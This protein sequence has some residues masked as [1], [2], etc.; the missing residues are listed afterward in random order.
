[1][2]C[3]FD[4]ENVFDVEPLA[5]AFPL[6]PGTNQ[7]AS[8]GIKLPVTCLRGLLQCCLQDISA[9]QLSGIGKIGLSETKVSICHSALGLFLG[10]S[11]IVASSASTFFYKRSLHKKK[12]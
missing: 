2:V 12:V 6:R 3:N 1:M 7:R 11:E 8:C 4:P 5:M 9:S 10:C